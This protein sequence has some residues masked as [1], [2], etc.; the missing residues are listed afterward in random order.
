MSY[1]R[2]PAPPA[3]P[4]CAGIPATGGLHL[5]EPGQKIV[6]GLCPPCRK[7]VAQ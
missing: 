4:I 7:E 6:D 2:A 1:A 5:A 3:G